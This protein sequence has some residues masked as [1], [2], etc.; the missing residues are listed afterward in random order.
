MC[1]TETK[2]GQRVLI[3]R[4]EGRDLRTLLIRI[5]ITEGSCLVCLEKIPFGP[6]MVR[7]NRQELALGR[8]V[9]RKIRVS[10]GAAG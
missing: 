9:A 3:S 10:E 8:E 6:F 7:H 5:G 4:I 1:L 2:R